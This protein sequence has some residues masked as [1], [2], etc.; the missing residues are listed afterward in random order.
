[1]QKINSQSMYVYTLSWSYVWNLPNDNIISSPP[2]PCKTSGLTIR[3]KF[4]KR[5]NGNSAMGI[6]ISISRNRH[7]AMHNCE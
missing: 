6:Y 5:G 4:A 1:M 7:P 2:P 3:K